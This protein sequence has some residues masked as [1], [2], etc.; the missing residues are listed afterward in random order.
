MRLNAYFGSIEMNNKHMNNSS[1]LS[2]PQAHIEIK[3]RLCQD[4]AF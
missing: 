1:N 3:M 4:L 2:Y